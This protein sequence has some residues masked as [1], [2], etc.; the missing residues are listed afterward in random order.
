MQP[1]FG[2]DRQ[3]AGRGSSAPDSASSVNNTQPES[4]QTKSNVLQAPAI[5]LPKGGG[6]VKSI[7]EKFSVNA[8]NGTASF[9][10]PL[11]VSPGRNGNTPSLSLS[12]SSGAGNGIFGLGWDCDYACIQRKTEKKLPEY[13]DADDSDTFIFSGAEDLVPE[14]IQEANGN[15]K[16]NTTTNNGIT[17]TRY[18]PRIEG[19]FARI[20]KIDDHNNTY[21]RVRTKQNVVFVFGETAAARLA[22]KVA[23][24]ENK[25]FK[26]C[27]EYTYDDKGN[28][29][30]YIYKQEDKAGI[31]PAVCE[32][33]R[34]KD[35]APFTNIYLKRVLYGNR[36][37]F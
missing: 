16:K 8:A 33:N 5:T 24:E 19:L 17:V 30:R 36:T 2:N 3:S 20:E 25:I 28:F 9:S 1:S 6:A 21:W 18:R 12:Y 23:G 32:K 37:A 7:D 15:W 27:L 14:L 13:R 31:I 10:I 4:A 29:T 22:S 34:L 35:T 11:P 26:W